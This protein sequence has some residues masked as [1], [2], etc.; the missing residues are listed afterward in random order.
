MKQEE[1]HIAQNAI[2]NDKILILIFLREQEKQYHG[3]I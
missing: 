3:E 2:N 1:I